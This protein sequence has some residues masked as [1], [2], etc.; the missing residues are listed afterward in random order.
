MTHARQ[1]C[2]PPF[3]IVTEA[4]G[5]LQMNARAVLALRGDGWQAITWAGITVGDILQVGS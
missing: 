5:A 3:S 2:M 4:R 1:L